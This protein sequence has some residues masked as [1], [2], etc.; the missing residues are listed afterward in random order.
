MPD[1]KQ[2]SAH[3]R[4]PPSQPYVYGQGVRTALQD[5]ATAY[6]FSVSITAAYGLTGAAKGPGGATET[7]CFA[8]G[9]AGAFMLVSLGFL[10]RF[11]HGRLGESQQVL[12]LRG[13]IDFV[14]VALAVAVAYGLS[15]IP[16][17]IAWPVTGLGTV[18][19]YLL[20][21]GVDVVLAQLLSRHTP[22]GR[23][24]EEGDEAD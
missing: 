12:G 7:V 13:G 19:A 18:V 9:A 4:P 3:D 22:L 23:S 11:R 21:G 17:L 6:G 24:Q 8:L 14:S 5:N 15:R 1:K 2:P 20:M 10:G 16:G